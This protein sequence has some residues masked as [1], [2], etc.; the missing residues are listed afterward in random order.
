MVEEDAESEDEDEEDVK[1][2]KYVWETFRPWKRKQVST[3]KS[4]TWCWWRWWNDDEHNDDDED[5]DDD[6]FEDAEAEE[7][8]PVKKSIRDS[9]QKCTEIKPEWERL[10]TINTKI[11]RSRILQKTGKNSKNT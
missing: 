8:A 11:K 3:E 10:K 9:S 7:R 5:D 4:K 2:P 6:D 1:T